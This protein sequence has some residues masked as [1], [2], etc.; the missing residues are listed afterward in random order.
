MIFCLKIYLVNTEK[1]NRQDTLAVTEWKEERALAYSRN[2]KQ[3]VN[4]LEDKLRV[5]LL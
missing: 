3:L 2:F 5:K 4:I 1:T